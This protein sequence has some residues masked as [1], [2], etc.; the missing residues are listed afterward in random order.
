MQHDVQLRADARAAYERSR[1]W[2]DQ[3]AFDEA[4]RLRLPSY[5]DAIGRAQHDRAEE[6][7]LNRCVMQLRMLV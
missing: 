4:E 6:W 2:V 3:P 5:L 7:E 1:L